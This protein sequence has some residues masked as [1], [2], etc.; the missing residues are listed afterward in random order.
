MQSML[1]INQ[2][3]KEG[4]VSILIRHAERYK[5]Q[6]MAEAIHPTLTEKGKND[7]FL[8][9]QELSQHHPLSIYY[10]PVTRCKETA[11]NIIR[12]ISSKNYTPHNGGFLLDLGGPYIKGDWNII[13]KIVDDIGQDIFIRKWFNGEYSADLIMPL[14]EAARLQLFL[15]V[16]QLQKEEHS[17]LNVTHDWNIMILREFFLDISHEKAGSPD[18]LDGL[19]FYLSNNN[20]IISNGEISSVI[21]ISNA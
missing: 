15:H 11:E 20:V 16:Q 4:K 18:F 2:I 19:Y 9:G 8:L 21:P 13:A 14:D 3:E 5:I 17:T 10:S 12:G 6:T 7:A 1:K